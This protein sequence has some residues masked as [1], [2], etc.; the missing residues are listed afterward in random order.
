MNARALRAAALTGT[1]VFAAACGRAPGAT[2]APDVR[3]TI[4]EDGSSAFVEV[5]GLPGDT[6]DA[7]VEAD[8]S[9]TDWSTL[10][11][12][13]V[14]PDAPA[15]LGAYTVEDGALRF[16]PR[17][18]LDPGRPYEVRFDPAGLKSS[19]DLPAL[20]AT[21]AM[22]GLDLEASTLVVRIHPTGDVVPANLLRMYV[23]FSA[24]MG[25]RSGLDYIELRDDRGALVEGPFLPLDYEF[26]N[27]DRTRFTV[28]FD[29][30]RVKEGILP[31]REMGR[32]L[33][34][35]RAYT[36]VVRADWPDGNGLPLAEEHRRTFEVAAADTRPLDETEWTIAA[37]AASSCDPVS[38][39][40]PEPLDHG[41]LV[42]AM[43]VAHDGAPLE[44][45][46]EVADG[47]TRWLFTPAMPWRAGRYELLAL[48]I[49][50]DLAG[51][52]IGRAFEVDVFDT[53][54]QSPEPGAVTL[55]FVID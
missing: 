17:F 54:D 8:Y 24:P 55:P 33:E 19:A 20:S 5:V 21:V 25:R 52:Q 10:L 34:P 9:T 18:P 27:A 38:V 41:L 4:P 7:L 49:L 28:F 22:P 50:E 31:N 37:P 16:R 42:R 40:F 39:T 26:W 3:L 29:P 12:V 47:E 15:M 2:P 6:L 48:G 35:G 14:E 23:E 11:R 43:G 53:V 45:E 13:A 44:G 30:G 51:N 1:L 32:A 36:F 46:I